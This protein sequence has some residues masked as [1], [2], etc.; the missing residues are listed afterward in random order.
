MSAQSSRHPGGRSSSEGLHATL[1]IIGP[2]A[3][4]LDRTLRE[5][6]GAQLD[7]VATR[8]PAQ[9]IRAFEQTPPDAILLLGSQTADERSSAAI[10]ALVQ[11]VLSR[12]L[13]RLIPILVL[14]HRPTSALSPEELAREL[15]V[16]RWLPL[17]ASPYEVLS[18]LADLLDLTELLHEPL[19]SSASSSKN[20]PPPP[21]RRET[22]REDTLSQETA[23]TRE[24]LVSLDQGILSSASEQ[25][26]ARV[27][28]QSLFPVRK[29][30]QPRGELTEEQVRKKLKEVRH[31]D[32]YTILEVRR[33]AET[34]VI[35]D[36]YMRMAALYDGARLDFAILHQCHQELAEIRDALE[37]AWAVLGDNDLRRLYLGALSSK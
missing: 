21:L 11:A 15:Q 34:P 1:L 18:A 32:Y 26:V 24:V 22:S 6:S 17:S 9:G 5:H 2:E 19:P 14:S 29:Q 28:R 13:G 36:A 27:E 7:I 3:A 31:E 4:D 16:A 8:L 23:P 30:E 25:S 12:P 20:R 37:D 35:K 33:G 10:D